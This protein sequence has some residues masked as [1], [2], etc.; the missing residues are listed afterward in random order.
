MSGS[1]TELSIEIAGLRC[2]SCR[3]E[4]A[5]EDEALRCGGCAQQF[6]VIAGIPDLRLAYP[7]PYLSM[8]EDLARAR[9]LEVR[10]HQLDFE[11]LLREHWRHRGRPPE[12]VERFVAGDLASLR[13]SHAY[14][15]QIERHRGAR[16]SSADRFLEIGCGTAGLAAAASARGA[17]VVAGDA[18]MCWLVLARKQLAEAGANSVGLVCFA[19]ERPPFAPGSFDIA[20]AS[21]VVEHVSSQEGFASGCG[22]LLRPGGLA[23]LATPNRFSLG[24][25]P[26][27]RLWGVGFLPRGLARRYVRVIRRAPYDHVRLLSARALGRLMRRHGFSAEV[28]PPEIPPATQE[29]YSGAEL[30]LVRAY[31]RLRRLGP[32]RRAL[33]WVGPFFHVFARKEAS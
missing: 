12:L 7:D 24:L 25:E 6:S 5:F 11:D 2:P 3:S 4:F 10:S 8:A 16:L 26:H 28:V 19:A 18:S 21:D 29:M 14:L 30:Q 23:F 15:E 33:L 9:E 1:A 32:V 31:N 17:Q 20:A 27:V 22:D 13:R